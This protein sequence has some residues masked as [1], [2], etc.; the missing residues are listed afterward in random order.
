MSNVR[1]RAAFTATAEAARANR[2]SGFT[3]LL[4]I[5]AGEK[6]LVRFRGAIRPLPFRSDED[7][8][9]SN[10][11]ALRALCAQWA[12]YQDVN[13][14]ADQQQQQQTQRGRPG[15]RP[16]APPPQKKRTTPA[17]LHKILV[18]RL[19]ERQKQVE[20]MTVTEDYIHNNAA[21]RRYVTCAQNW[22]PSAPCVS[23]AMKE[24]GDRRISSKV[25]ANFSVVPHR[26]YH[27]VKAKKEEDNE[28]AY[29]SRFGYDASDE[30]TYCARNIEAKQ[31]GMKR[32]SIAPMH[33]E[34]LFGLDDRLAKKC[35][36]C[37]GMG[38][39]DHICWTCCGC[40]EVF[41]NGLKSP[42]EEQYECSSCHFVGFAIE[43]VKCSRGCVDARRAQLYDTD[44][45]IERHGER[46][47]TTYSFT[48][49]YPF[50]PAGPEI[51]RFR[52]PTWEI[53]LKP[54]D[55]PGQCREIGVR[56][57]P[58]DGTDVGALGPAG[59]AQNYD[60]DSG[61]ESYEGEAPDVSY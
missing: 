3:R 7:L 61:G 2:G 48:E 26:Q 23:C 33:A 41:E 53:A 45:L 31:E 11:G 57:N 12:V 9:K 37:Q 38:K 42:H 28:F 36:A 16:A 29:C 17:D 56:I 40:G 32:F 34:V 18:E 59:G 20:P 55:V 44:I 35:A 46:K 15:Q 30:C 8:K 1:G 25:S 51:L 10:L 39:I 14:D 49:Q 24:Q 13:E 50:E 47:S 58:F 60:S 4:M 19:I 21:G 5:K 22:T 43:E 54:K 52:L 6:V 27:Y